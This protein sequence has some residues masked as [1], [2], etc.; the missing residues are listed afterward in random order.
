MTHRP[1]RILVI[2]DDCGPGDAL[3]SR[4]AVQALRR[5]HPD[6]RLTLVVSEQ[7]A[8]VFVSDPTADRVVTSSLYRRGLEGAWR[9]RAHKLAELVRLTFAVGVGHDLCVVLNWGTLTL[10]LL[11]RVAAR[12]V[13]GFENRFA[14]LTSSRLGPYDVDG[15]PAAQNRALLVAADIG[16]GGVAAKYADM[17]TA[18]EPLAIL[19]TG[20]DW[21]CQQWRP[22]AW[23]QVGDW[24]LEECG[25]AVV[26]TGLAEEADYVASI[27]SLMHGT[28]TSLAGATSF[29]Q[30]SSLLRRASL[31]VT[32]D[33]A[34]Y[35]MAQL[36]GTPTVVVAGP[37]AAVARLGRGQPSL[38]VN[39]TRPALQRQ[40]LACQRTFADGH[41]HDYACPFAQLPLVQVA[42]VIA[43]IRRIG[44]V[45][46]PV[47]VPV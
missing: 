16:D 2:A 21:A 13:I 41:C 8:E 42:D 24:L 46:A 29:E 28:S 5:A 7:A 1:R 31:L 39:H 37:T 25:L 18:R 3:R 32:V 47:A 11:G 45:D 19:H 27:Q 26:F 35:E 12:E 36:S 4:F 20:S 38:V 34:P 14:W 17:E 44:P 10:D 30:L 43:A 15:D 40:I 6:S 23:A 9:R 22:E 33:S